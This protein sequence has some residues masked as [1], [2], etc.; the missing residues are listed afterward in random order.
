MKGIPFRMLNLEEII[1][2]T[3]VSIICFTNII[4]WFYKRR[5]LEPDVLG[6]AK[7][8]DETHLIENNFDI[9]AFVKDWE[10]FEKSLDNLEETNMKDLYQTYMNTAFVKDWKSFERI[11]DNIEKTNMKNLY[12]IYIKMYRICRENSSLLQ[13]NLSKEEID[14]LNQ[15]IKRCHDKLRE[16]GQYPYIEKLEGK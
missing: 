6:E 8:E 7:K 9:T 5:T 13:K 4:V 16:S 2:I 10:S 3:C 11:S 14:Q 15:R 12:R 1:I